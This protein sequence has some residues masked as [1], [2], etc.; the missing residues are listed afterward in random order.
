MTSRF[1]LV[2]QLRHNIR[3]RESIQLYLYGLIIDI[4]ARRGG[5]DGQTVHGAPPLAL[6]QLGLGGILRDAAV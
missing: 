5:A 4:F 3:Y 6:V 1:G 2:Q